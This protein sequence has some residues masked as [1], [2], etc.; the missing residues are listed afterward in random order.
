[1]IHELTTKGVAEY[2]SSRRN[3]GG[4][5]EQATPT[6]HSVPAGSESDTATARYISRMPGVLEILIGSSFGILGMASLNSHTVLVVGH[7]LY[8]SYSKCSHTVLSPCEKM[9]R[10]SS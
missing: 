10:L 9:S 7:N 2:F 5:E 6:E 4:D 8:D 3:G 1:M